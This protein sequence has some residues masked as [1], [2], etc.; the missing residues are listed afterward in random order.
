MAYT[1]TQAVQE[2]RYLLNEP[3]ASFWTDTEIEGW[4]QQAAMDISVKTLCTTKEG[5]IT[6]VQNQMR[7]TST[8]ET[9]LEDLIKSE[10]VWFD[11]GTGTRG[12]QRVEPHMFGHLQVKSAGEPR[13]FYEDGKK[14]F[15]W[16]KPD[17][18][19]SGKDLSIIYSTTTND[20]TELREEY[21]QLTFL[22]ATSM[23]KAKDRKFQ[24]AQLYQQLYLN[25]LNFERQDKHEMGTMPTETF[26]QV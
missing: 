23:A 19:A 25:A 10:V 13:Y 3:S 8:D 9:W 2:V 4:I 22:Y 11:F 17:A 26:K 12:L 16:P 5:T 14:F 7:Y 20:I 1:L 21:Q 6:L 18:T 24:E 15:I